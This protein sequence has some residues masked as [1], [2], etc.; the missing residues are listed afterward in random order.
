MG[1]IINLGQGKV[2]SE[3]SK[4]VNLVIAETH[5]NQPPFLS[6]PMLAKSA[7]TSTPNP[8]SI[9][10]E[11]NDPGAEEA[12]ILACI[13]GVGT[14]VTDYF[15]DGSTLYK[16]RAFVAKVFHALQFTERET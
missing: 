6:T 2:I 10:D 15:P 9:E 1:H 14:T 11:D 12:T 3:L 16:A 13:N 7:S 5:E 8:V 4:G